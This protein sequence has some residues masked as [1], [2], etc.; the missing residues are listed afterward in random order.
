MATLTLA[1]GANDPVS[2]TLG[3]RAAFR[4][5]QQTTAWRRYRKASGLETVVAEEVTYG[6][7]GWHPH[8]HIAALQRHHGDILDEASRWFEAWADA[9]SRELGSK[10][11]PSLE[12]GVDLLDC[13][14]GEYLAKLGLELA[15]PGEAKGGALGWAASTADEMQLEREQRRGRVRG[16]SPLE[17]VYR[18]ELDRYFELMTCRRRARDIT[19]SRG[20]K[21]IRDNEP[22][23]ALDTTELAVT[24]IDFE[25]V[26]HTRGELGLLEVLDV[27]SEQGLEAAHA[28]IERLCH[29]RTDVSSNEDSQPVPS[30]PSD[31]PHAER[32]ARA[33]SAVRAGD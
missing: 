13:A 5:M 8:L 26:K 24:A 14:P 18:S 19:Y 22:P 10:H 21:S 23:P 27:A 1:H 6:A 16:M 25:M 28:A 30:G 31:R 17:L 9:V 15:D 29:R 20:L 3:V 2:L 11:E 7:N 32:R 12:H 4:R 33:R